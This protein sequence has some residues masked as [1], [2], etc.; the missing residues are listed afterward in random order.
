MNQLKKASFLWSTLSVLAVSLMAVHGA[1]ADTGADSGIVNGSLSDAEKNVAQS[2]LIAES[3]QI[4][5]SVKG[6]NL[7]IV[8]LDGRKRGDVST[9]FLKS[10]LKSKGVNSNGGWMPK[11]FRVLAYT[12][13]YSDDRAFDSGGLMVTDVQPDNLVMSKI[14]V[15]ESLIKAHESHSPL[16]IDAGVLQEGT[17]LGQAMGSSAG[18]WGGV[19]ANLAVNLTRAAFS[20]S[21]PSPVPMD[22]EVK[23]IPISECNASCQKTHHVVVFTVLY[24]ADP[25]HYYSLTLERVDDKI[26]EQ[27]LTVLA[28]QGLQTVAEKIAQAVVSN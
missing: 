18:V 23:S 3:G 6:K 1:L 20:G 13:V 5:E 10:Y 14:H 2:I 19:V 25:G 7:G 11:A 27:N 17:K 21:K 28:N 24:D 26:N 8:F 16:K 4:D 15:S 9:T 12:H 22:R